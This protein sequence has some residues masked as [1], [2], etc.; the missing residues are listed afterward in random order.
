MC[1]TL[2]NN[3]KQTIVIAP[4]NSVIV[5]VSTGHNYFSTFA[6]KFLEFIQAC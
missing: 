1:S 3:T 5:S 4:E 2:I 6:K